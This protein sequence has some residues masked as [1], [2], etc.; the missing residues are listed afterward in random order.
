MKDD[1]KC[2]DKNYSIP[3]LEI[4]KCFECENDIK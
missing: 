2:E 1:C 4:G 3:E